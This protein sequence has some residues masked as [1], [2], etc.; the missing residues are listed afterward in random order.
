MKFKKISVLI[1]LC[2]VGIFLILIPNQVHASTYKTIK[3]TYTH[4][5]Y[6][7]QL[8]VHAASFKKSI[9]VWNL[10]HTKVRYNLKDH[11]ATTYSINAITTFSHNGKKSVYYHIYALSPAKD[12]KLNGGYVWHKYLA[13]G[14]NPNYNLI[15][16][17]DI[18]HFGNSKEYQTYIKES[19]SQALTRKILALFPHSTVSLDLSLASLKYNKNTYDITNIQSINRINALNTYLNTANTSSNAQ[20]YAKIKDYLLANGYTTSYRNKKLII[21]IYYNGFTFHSWDDGMMV[22]GFATGIE[23]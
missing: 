10:N 7:S 9:Y 21:G 6:S 16:N 17:E 13:K 4:P 18:M 11:P 22:Q 8:L 20:R 14:H 15:N 23:K 5:E 19:P 2:S 1:T 12:V 3:T